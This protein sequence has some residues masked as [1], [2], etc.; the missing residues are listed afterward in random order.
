MKPWITDAIGT[1]KVDDPSSVCQADFARPE[2]F[3]IASQ[4]AQVGQL[5][6]LEQR[7]DA[8][9]GRQVIR[10]PALPGVELRVQHR[11]VFRR[12]RRREDAP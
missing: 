2:K 3:S 12:G 11:V 10:S 1:Q 5:A 9:N 6:G 8:S 4:V 7:S